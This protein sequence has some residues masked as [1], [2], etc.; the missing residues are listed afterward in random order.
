MVNPSHTGNNA[1]G[2]SNGGFNR[3]GQGNARPPYQPRSQPINN[4]PAELP[5][6]TNATTQPAAVTTLSSEN[7]QT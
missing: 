4:A 6:Q 3:N 5:D 7:V 2:S 1:N